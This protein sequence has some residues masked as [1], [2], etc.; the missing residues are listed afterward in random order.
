MVFEEDGCVLYWFD[1]ISGFEGIPGLEVLLP[2]ASTSQLGGL[3][4]WLAGAAVVGGIAAAISDHND[5]DTKIPNGTLDIVEIK[6]NGVIVGKTTNIPT[7]SEVIVTIKG[8]DKDGNVVEEQIK[9]TVGLDGSF[10]V[11]V[12]EKIVDGSSVDVTATTTD[13]NGNNVSDTD[14]L[15]GSDAPGTGIDRT[16]SEIKVTAHPDGSITGTTTDVPAN[17]DVVLTITGK[18]ANGND[19]EITRT[20]QTDANGNYDYQLV[21]GD[22]IVDGSSVD[23]EAVTTDRNGNSIN[24]TDTLAAQG[25]NDNDPLTPEDPGL[26]LVAGTI[27]VDINETGSITGTTTD[28]PANS[29]VVLTITG[30][31]ANG[32]DVEITRTVQ[33]DANGNYDYQLVAGDGI[34]DG[35]SVDVEAVTTDRNGNSINDTDTLA[36]Q[37]D[38]DNDPL[39]PED[40][41]LDLVAGTIT[42]DI[43]ETGSITGT[44]TDV[45]ANSDVVLTITGKDAN[46]NDVEI[47]RTVQTDA[48]GNYDYQLVAGDGIV[49]GSSVDVEAV[50]TDRNGNSINDTDTLAAQGD[51]DND[52]LTP[53][54]PGLDLVAGTITVDINE[55][56]SITG[57]TTD[58]PA[59]SDVV[60][61]ITGKDANGN[62]VEITRTVQTDAN[63]NYDYQLVAGDGIVDGSSVDVEAVTTDRNGNSIN[64]TDTLA[65]QGDNDNDPLTPEDPGLDLVAGTITVDINETGSITGTT[66]DV[67][68]NSDVVLT[69]T[70]KDANGNDVEITRTVQTDANGNY[71]Y[72]LVAG[73]GIVDGSSV[74]VEAVT[75]DRNG[76]SINDTDTLAAQGDNDNDPLTPEDPGLD[77]VAGTITV[78]INETG[79]ITGTTTDVPAN[80]DVV[81]TIT[82]KDANG[83][84]VEI[85]R[86]VQTD[87]NGNYDYQLVAGD[88]IVDGSSVDVEAVTTDRN[89]NS[90]NDTD[91]LAAQGDNDNDPLTP[92]DPGLD[93]VAG[94]IT[95]DINETGS[96]TGTTTDVPANSDVVLT[97][98]GKDA[99]GND[100]EITR[101][102]QTDA[103]GNYDYQ[104]VAGDGIV[105]GSSVDVEAVTTDRNGNSIN[106]T[107]T[108]AAQGDND[109]DPL[110]PED[111]GLDLVAGTIT[112]DINETGSI[113]GTTTDVP[114]NSDVVLTITGKDAN[115]NDVEIT[116][117]VQTDANGNYDYQLV[118]GDGIVD[119]SSVDVEAVTTDRNGNSINDTDTLAAQ[120]DND[121]DPL[122]PEDPG[123]DLVAGTITVDINETGS[124]TGTTTDVPANSDVVLTIT[125]K[126]ANGND[127][128]IT[129]TVQT[130]ANGNYDYQ[131]V[132]GDGIVDGS[133]VD[134]EAVTT[135]RNGNSIN[136]TDTLAAQGD[137]DNDPLT[138][139]DP[140]LDLVAGTITVDINETGSITGTTTDVPAN[141]DVVLTITGKDANG[142]DVEITRTVQTDANGNYDYQLVAG[143]GIVDGSSV[144]VEAVTTDRNGNS[145][146][147]T[148]TLAAQGDNDN[149]PLTPEDPGLDL[150]AGTITVD[151]NETGSITG[152][153]TD[154]PANSDVVLT[155]TGKDANGNDV[156]ITRTVQTDAN[157]N[158][159]YQLVAGDGIVDGSSVDV[160]AVTTDRNGNSINDTDTLAAQGDNDNDPLTPEDP[161]LD[162]VAGTI[163]VDINETGSITG[164]TTDVP[165]NS[166]VVLT[167]TGKDANGNDVEIT[168]TVQTDANGNYDYQ[169]V[170]GDGIVDGSSVDVEAV[171][172]DRNGNS[173]NDTD[174]L[175]AQGDNDN[176]P[177][178]PEDPGLDLVAGTITVDINETGS[179]TGTTT[180]VPANSDVVLTITGKDANGNDVEITRTVQTDANGNYDYQ[181]VAGDGIVDGSSVDVEA[182]TTDRN[183]NSIND[184]DTLAAQGDNDNDPLTPEDPGLDLVAGTITVDINETGSITGTTTDVPANSD[185]VLT[186][187][188]KDA[189]GN[190]VEITRTV[191]TDANGNYDYQLVAGDGIVDGSSVDVEAVTTDR[192]GNSINDTDTLAAQGDNDNDPL[193]PED[194]GLD[195]VAG[196]ITVDINET[197]S[198]T[199]TTTDVPANSDVVL[200][201]TG[202]DANGNDVEITRTVQTDANGNYDYQLV[203][204]DGIVD[205]SSVDV[206]AVT[207]DRNGNSINDTDTLAAQGDNDNDPLTPEDPGLDLVAGTIT[208]DINETG[209]I[210]GTTTDVPANSDVV[211]TITGKDANGNDVEI[212]RTV[213]TDAN[214]NYDYQLVAG[215]GIVDGSSV[216]VEAVTTDRNGNSINDTDT[217]AAQGDN[218]ND[219]L[220]PEDPGLDLVAGTITVDIN[221]TG[222]ITGTTTDVPANSDVVLTITGKDANGNDVEITRTVQTDANGNYDYQLVAGDGIVDGS[223][224]DVEAV[225]TDRNG[226]S[227]NDT[228][229]LAAQGDNDNDPLTP[230]DPGL[231]LVAGTITVDIEDTGT[232]LISGTTTDVAPGETVTL[233]IQAENN[234]DGSPITFTRDVIVQ[235]DGSY[236]Y[237]LIPADNVR[238]DSPV[239]VVATTTDRNGNS[240]N[241]TDNLADGLLDLYPAVITVDIVDDASGLITGT[242]EY[243]AAGTD[244]ILTIKGKDATGADIEITRTVQTDASGNYSYQLLVNDGIV[245]GSSVDVE[246]MTTNTKG[247]SVGPA[248]DTL[249]AQ[250]DNDNDPLTPEDSGLDLIAGTITV[251]ITD[252]D[253]TNITGTTTDVAPGSTVTLNITSIDDMGETRVFTQDVITDASGNYSYD[254]TAV[255]GNAIDVTAATHD[256]NGNPL[257]AEDISEAVVKADTDSN[258]SNGDNLVTGSSGNDVLAGDIGGLYTNF[259]AGQNYNV[260]V[261]LDLS[262][263]MAW[264]LGD[265]TSPE[266]GEL[267]RLEIAIAGLK[268]FVQQMAYHDGTINLQIA[269]FS[270]NGGIGNGYNQTFM[271]VDQSNL[272]AILG[273]LDNLQTGGG[274]YPE[275]GFDKATNWFNN[276]D[277]AN[278]TANGFENQT[279]YLT[280]GEPTV[281]DPTTRDTA[282][283][284]LAD[285]SKVYA[286]GISE[287][288]SLANVERYDNTDVNGDLIP[289]TWNGDSN[290]GTAQRF[291][292]QDKLISYLI[293]GKEN[294]TPA[295]VGND[296]V[297]GGAGDDVLFGDAINTN[298]LTWVGKD[299]LQYPPYSGYSALVEYLRV[300]V[301]GGRTNTSPNLRFCQS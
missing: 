282:F 125:G 27:T 123:L 16:P 224:V 168:R 134:V 274:T 222:S 188:G 283:A 152:T 255:E 59:N 245:D 150:V 172:T 211:L 81:L 271:T 71:D 163:T 39:T 4:P 75:T 162:L 213:Q 237:Q 286:V 8:K 201:I 285:M 29:D 143:D 77:L 167:I 210:T 84:D 268:A 54:D 42:V 254:L 169:L 109:N 111:P 252:S 113:T 147:D 298:W 141:S 36:A 18:D 198:I 227:I 200:T 187:T 175:A 275:F 161:G 258:V 96:I 22:G 160:E 58:V 196:T 43:N 66:T 218:D 136:D 32:N 119:G 51:N 37:G 185:V 239:D 127:V 30:K 284:P 206:E 241:D 88:G 102:V 297:K 131:L 278:A 3:L 50:T 223:S 83:N 267:S 106:D 170:A 180:D 293:S 2:I 65:A 157:G 154:V 183:G 251:D 44:T 229:T 205:G 90:I 189:N 70:G 94:T 230:E 107:D 118:A 149:D 67:P 159:D 5:N 233:E 279:Y 60:L 72:Q 128:E 226:N 122:T 97:I 173:I 264:E 236:L 144:D 176:D 174:T 296:I 68:A 179:I 158:Y 259:I 11:D 80:S 220:T 57:T 139:E 216:D 299:N 235:P 208:V 55:T 231:D 117:T 243:V 145:I 257:Q 276:A 101:T 56:G 215:D 24:D 110:T 182:V 270:A 6:T 137:N 184:T 133:S 190:D 225:T 295:N 99:N 247:N 93:L 82:G 26:D 193:T 63:G 132:A 116:R 53:E 177:L 25:D 217:L 47:T 289:G 195:L 165:A 202:K 269:S 199:G 10:E 38:N 14:V 112:V 232:G 74:D 253:T 121:N 178:T 288:V 64:D 151:I 155:I 219:P 41:G 300:E 9:T 129:R 256:R 48:N 79:S 280:D 95:V 277:I 171:T 130:D 108:L 294:W 34:V 197:G 164:T 104:L 138:P 103:N 194:P 263:S 240:V 212:T 114:A 13:R 266:S 87:A 272:Q 17:S 31:D 19:V 28:V 46:G 153:T 115:G 260:S 204:G 265:N 15:S 35:S 214:G 73:D 301:T 166:D 156:E 291:T 209:S 92:E 135:D 78:D 238:Q 61:T 244:V 12:P 290:H 262:G 20:V 89:G 49:D 140:G 148:D 86:T 142:N 191:Q 228:D 248:I 192:N 261:V 23:V 98:T 292:D 1:G 246:A 69:I 40:P 250:G 242:T 120:G 124:I 105:D 203:A 62:D 21:A 249:A 181:L 7:G 33:T 234:T 91:T 273:Y 52:P 146:N 100:V 221:E 76:N 45:P 281:A 287:A 126:D 85:T 186:I 207:T